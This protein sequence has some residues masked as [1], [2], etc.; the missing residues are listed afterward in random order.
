MN[1]ELIA[2][3]IDGTLLNSRKKVEPETVR[4]VRD[5]C[6]AG[7][8]VAFNTGRAVCELTELFALLPEVRYA[9]FASGAG[10]YDVQERKTFALHG[11]PAE[12]AN[13]IFA[14]AR[15]KDIMPQIVLPGSDVIQA[16][17]LECLEHF[18]MGIYRP[19]YE[20]AMTLVPDICAFAASCRE[21]MLKINLY[22]AI[23]EERIRSSAQ[24]SALAIERVYSEESSLECSARGVDKGS[25]LLR[26]CNELGIPPEQTIAAGDADNDLPMLRAAGIGVAM[27]NAAE[28]VKAAADRV[29]SDLDHGGCA[30]AIRMLLSE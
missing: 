28:H 27:G 17:H 15:T 1:Y 20:Q 3:D 7:K 30:Q 13:T 19:L 11:I 21:P 24:L 4:A 12:A 8:T 6:A 5:A 23:P 16:S 10:L 18:H 25:G 9:V 2:L 22:H 29:V 26:L 14:L